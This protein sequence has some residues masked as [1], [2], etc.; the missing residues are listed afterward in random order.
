MLSVVWPTDHSA[1]LLLSGNPKDGA[2]CGVRKV[3]L[4][5]GPG[6]EARPLAVLPLDAE[7]NADRLRRLCQIN[8]AILY[9]ARGHLQLLRVMQYRDRVCA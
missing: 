9:E 5:P 6:Q 2:L 7:T 4:R 3:C 1:E 8:D